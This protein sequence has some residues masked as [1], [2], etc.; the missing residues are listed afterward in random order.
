MTTGSRG[1][2]SLTPRGEGNKDRSLAAELKLSFQGHPGTLGIT[3]SEGIT[4]CVVSLPFFF[5]TF[6]KKYFLHFH[7]R[8]GCQHVGIQNVSTRKTQ[9][10]C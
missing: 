6:L 7:L 8:F 1:L 3:F 5:L 9:E 4:L 2:L 10:K